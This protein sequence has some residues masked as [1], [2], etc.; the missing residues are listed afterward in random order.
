VACAGA[1]RWYYCA[2]ALL[3]TGTSYPPGHQQPGGARSA[4]RST[5]LACMH[6]RG[7]VR[8]RRRCPCPAAVAGMLTAL[9]AADVCVCPHHPPRPTCCT[10]RFGGAQG[11]E[12]AMASWWWPAGACVALPGLQPGWRRRLPAGAGQRRT[13]CVGALL[14]GWLR[15]ADRCSECLPRPSR[16]CAYVLQCVGGQHGHTAD[17]RRAN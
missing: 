15:M 14:D 11:S 12:H 16:L 8:T 17:G 13:G 4:W 9:L 2:A 7:L 1:C 5:A 10:D 6:A 3:C